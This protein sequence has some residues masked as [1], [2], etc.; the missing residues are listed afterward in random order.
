MLAGLFG[1]L[2][3]DGVLHGLFGDEI[4]RALEV[5]L[6]TARQCHEAVCDSGSFGFEEHDDDIDVALRGV[7]AFGYCRAEDAKF[8]HPQSG[9]QAADGR[10]LFHKELWSMGFMSGCGLWFWS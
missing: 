3:E 6:Q 9:A 8:P 1:R 7:E 5:F 4:D 10:Y 2:A